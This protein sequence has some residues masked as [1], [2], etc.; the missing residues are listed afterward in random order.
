MAIH[1]RVHIHGLRHARNNWF[2]LGILD[3]GW[4]IPI[5]LYKKKGEIYSYLS[6]L[7]IAKIIGHFVCE[8]INPLRIQVSLLM[9]Q[10]YWLFD[11]PEFLTSSNDGPNST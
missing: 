4:E 7:L 3:I 5:S 11:L 9:E 1:H 2:L 6:G 10:S 8:Q